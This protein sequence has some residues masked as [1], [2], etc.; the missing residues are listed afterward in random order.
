[1]CQVRLSCS[2][3][4]PG[5]TLMRKSKDCCSILT[6]DALSVGILPGSNSNGGFAPVIFAKLPALARRCV[7]SPKVISSGLGLKL[8]N[9]AGM[10]LATSSVNRLEIFQSPTNSDI[11]STEF[12][13][14]VSATCAAYEKGEPSQKTK[15]G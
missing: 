6:A 4:I 7:R 13:V 14:Q 10:A 15:S 1:M 12:R 9:S 3:V 11:S 8:W 2:E 5:S